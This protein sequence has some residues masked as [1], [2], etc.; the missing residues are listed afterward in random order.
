M[1]PPYD[2]KVRGLEDMSEKP[3]G[4]AS[5]ES[6]LAVFR[7]DPEGQPETSTYTQRVTSSEQDYVV[8]AVPSMSNLIDAKRTRTEERSS[9]STTTE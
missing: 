9:S 6:I 1:T 5:M 8:A 4:T 7:F 3:H 2:L